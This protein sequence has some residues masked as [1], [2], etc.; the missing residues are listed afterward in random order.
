M[1]T[2]ENDRVLVNEDGQIYF[3][4]LELETEYFPI[5]K[6]CEDCGPRFMLLEDDPVQIAIWE[7]VLYLANPLIHCA[8]VKSVTEA[9]SVLESL[10]SK[11]ETPKIIISDIFVNGKENGVDLW[12]KFL[13]KN[14]NGP[15][16][17]MVSGI[18]TKNYLDFFRDDKVVPPPYLQ[19]PLDISSCVKRVVDLLEKKY[20]G[21]S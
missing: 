1:N 14:P 7:K 11:G 10:S 6:W 19:K 3:L 21:L 20:V 4:D 9:E 18:S 12:R 2:E 15:E 13:K 8:W 5:R 16:F 17:L